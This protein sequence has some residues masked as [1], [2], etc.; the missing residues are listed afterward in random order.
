MGLS[1]RAIDGQVP[2]AIARPDSLAALAAIVRD[3]AATGTELVAWGGGT[4]IGVGDP[5][6]GYRLAVELGGL[7]GVVAHEP[8]DLVAIVR[9]GTTLAALAAALAPSGQRWPVEVGDPEHA[10]VGGVLAGA[11][12]GPS[13]LAAFHPRDWVI[14][15]TAVLGDGSIAKAGGR[16]VKNVSGYDLTKLYSGSHGTLAIIAEV[17]LKLTAAPAASR[18]LVAA[19]PDLATG[20]A[21]AEALLAA[22]LPVD[23]LAVHRDGRG[24]RIIAR[25]AGVPAAVDRIAGILA[26]RLGAVEAEPAPWPAL[27]ARPLRTAFTARLVSPLPLP[28][29]LGGEVLAYPGTGT[30]YLLEAPGAEALRALR[31]TLE[32][33]GGALVIE[34]A[35]P[36][37][38]AA[39]GGAW[40]RATLPLAIAAALKARFDP[41]RILAPGRMPGCGG[42]S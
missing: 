11:A 20:C 32:G 5:P 16:V 40:G 38:R 33:H 12:F 29:R 42:P 41:Q 4:R 2:A 27:A 21:R 15:V 17:A 34:R 7:C 39:A 14:G 25:T 37:L 22:G 31:A 35:D 23:A 9:A 26:E 28:D 18:T 36:A 10:T 30:A 8:G 3:A 1:G 6:L 13:R 19:V 24:T